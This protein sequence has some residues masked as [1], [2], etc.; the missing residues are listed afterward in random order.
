ML[1][2]VISQGE[3]QV[4]TLPMWVLAFYQPCFVNEM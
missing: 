1:L 3:A 2:T 4:V